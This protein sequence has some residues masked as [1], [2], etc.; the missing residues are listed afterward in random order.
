VGSVIDTLIKK[1]K[2]SR[3]EFLVVSET[4]L[5]GDDTVSRTPALLALEDIYKNGVLKHS[6][7]LKKTPYCIHPEYL[8]YKIN[9]SLAQTKLK[10][11]DVSLLANPFEIM[12]TELEPKEI[13]YRLARAFE[14]YEEMIISNKLKA[15]GVSSF[16]WFS[17]LT[18]NP[19]IK[20]LK[21]SEKA[22]LIKT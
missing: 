14:F 12:S 21:L 16:S 9:Q 4:G 5:L 11:I 13:L 18:S 19:K 6:D 2:Y 20:Y 7:I 22:D 15:Y 8:K 3:E 1:Y 10:S 17:D